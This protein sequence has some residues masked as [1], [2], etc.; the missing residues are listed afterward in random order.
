MTGTTKYL[1]IFNIKWKKIRIN[2]ST[3]FSM[4]YPKR[5]RLLIHPE[6]KE[7]VI[8][9]CNR[10]EPL[11]FRVPSDFGKDTHGFELSSTQLTALLY[12]TM[13]WDLNKSYRV[14]GNYIE[15]ENIVVFPLSESVEIM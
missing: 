9:P 4:G 8:Q 13:G 3:I 2:Q 10:F 11:S 1:A 14:L 6:K 15:K 5:V 12:D 7:L